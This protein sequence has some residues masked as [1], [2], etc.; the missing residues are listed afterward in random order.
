MTRIKT[1]RV[2]LKPI[3]T[4]TVQPM[5]KKPDPFYVS[6]AW[7]KLMEE[8]YAERGRTC[9]QCGRTSTRLFGDHIVELRDG[10]APL[11]KSNVKI[12]C[13]SCH[14]KK[15]AIKRGERMRERY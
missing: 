6:A 8:L 2:G 4:R 5:K 3:D 7:R 12:M 11:D 1:I 14:Q 10:G 15:S 9:E 13:G